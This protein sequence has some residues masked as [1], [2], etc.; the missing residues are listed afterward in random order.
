MQHAAQLVHA[1][2]IQRGANR[3][4]RARLALLLALH[5]LTSNARVDHLGE[6][7]VTGLG[8][9][10]P[11]AAHLLDVLIGQHLPQNG[12]DRVPWPSAG[13][14]ALA[15]LPWAEFACPTVSPLLFMAILHLRELTRHGEP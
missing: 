11:T 10:D 12:R 13:I 7:H 14:S 9:R 1:V 3:I 15:G 2:F 8:P 6:A 4:E 5:G